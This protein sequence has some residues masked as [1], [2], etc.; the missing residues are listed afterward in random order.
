MKKFKVIISN[1]LLVSVLLVGVL[2][3]IDVCNHD[4]C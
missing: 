3:I 1:L 2:G 4:K